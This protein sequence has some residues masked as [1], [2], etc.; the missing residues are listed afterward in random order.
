MRRLR[1]AHWRHVAATANTASDDRFWC[2]EHQRDCRRVWVR[3]EQTVRLRQ[4]TRLLDLPSEQRLEAHHQRL[5]PADDSEP[6]E[7]L[8]LI[9]V[10]RHRFRSRLR[11]LWHRKA[12][13]A[14]I[15][16]SSEPRKRSR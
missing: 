3:E 10:S 15:F 6:V 9:P 8:E 13:R 5:V 1:S 12:L 16:R 7:Q 2:A 14:R 4:Q 11:R